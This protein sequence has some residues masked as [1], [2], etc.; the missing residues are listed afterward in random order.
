MSHYQVVQL[1]RKRPKKQRCEEKNKIAKTPAGCSAL[2]PAYLGGRRGAK[3]TVFFRADRPARWLAKIKDLK[4]A[5]SHMEKALPVFRAA[6]L[7]DSS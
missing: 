6:V 7:E 2:W 4:G 5:S 1:N 3:K